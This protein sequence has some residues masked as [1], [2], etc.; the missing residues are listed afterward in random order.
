MLCQ[1]AD[2]NSVPIPALLPCHLMTLITTAY[3]L[4]PR[5]KRPPAH[6]AP[7]DTLGGAVR[8]GML[9]HPARAPQPSSPP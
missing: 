1:Q 9:R 5:P 6:P 2:V 4:L 8:G 3:A 7:C